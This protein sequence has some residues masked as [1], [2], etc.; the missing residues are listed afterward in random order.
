[1]TA[2]LLDML[3]DVRRSL[4]SSTA[5][6]ER[7][8]MGQFLTPVSIARFM[9]SLFTHGG[10]DVR[11]LDPGAGA[12]VLF[13]ALVEALVSNMNRPESIEVVAYENDAHILPEL[14]RTTERCRQI[15]K[16][17]CI[18]FRCVVRRKRGRLCCCYRT[19]RRRA[20]RAQVGTVYT[21]HIESTL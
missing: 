1:M 13:A 17:A 15:C 10:K 8:S 12:G 16:E 9:A 14:R 7:S 5:R 2:H 6:N 18:T 3:D 19:D 4:N 11:I 21:C 20:L